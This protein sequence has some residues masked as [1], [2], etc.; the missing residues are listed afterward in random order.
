MKADTIIMYRTAIY[1]AMLSEK[2]FVKDKKALGDFVDRFNNGSQ[3][4]VNNES[5]SIL[6]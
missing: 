3:C 6:R 2:K 5:Y 4:S 1:A